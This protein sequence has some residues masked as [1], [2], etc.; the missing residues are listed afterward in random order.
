[1]I[2]NKV[3]SSSFSRSVVDCNLEY[4]RSFLLKWM[5][6]AERRGVFVL[7]L[8]FIATCPDGSVRRTAR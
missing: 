6:S 4:N 3:D 8:A 1:M 2:G 5:H 7:F